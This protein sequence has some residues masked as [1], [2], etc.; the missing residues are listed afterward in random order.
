MRRYALLLFLCACTVLSSD[1]SQRLTTHKRNAALFFEGGKLQQ[2][3]MQAER[4]LEID[5]DDYKLNVIKGAVLLRMSGDDPKK[6]D[7]AT[8]ILARVFDWRSPRRH[9]HYELLYYGLAEQ[10]HGLRKLA[11]AIRLDDEARRKPASRDELQRQADAARR[12]AS[13]RMEHADEL[14]SVLVDNGD[15]LLSAHKHRLLLASQLGW[16]QRFRDSTEAFLQQVQK[17]Q[18]IAERKIAATGTPEYEAEL[19][20]VRAD[21]RR[22]ELEV[23]ALY[24]DWLYRRKDYETARAQLDR[25]LELDPS[26]S[27]DYYNRG[28]VLVELGKIEAAKADFTRFLSTSH[29]PASS[30]KRTYAARI[31]KM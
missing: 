13:A 25:V 27:S 6:L 1:E 12:A 3:L 2:A 31:L 16:D 29:L 5:P 11:E 20:R 26:R 8:R 10:K 19:M 7:E 24:A 4:G 22:D 14:F 9:E 30:E 15:L 21:L 18:E 28:R 23:R 17:E